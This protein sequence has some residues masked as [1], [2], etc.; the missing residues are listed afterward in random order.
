M[1]TFFNTKSIVG[2]VLI[3]LLL[4]TGLV[5]ASTFAVNM[6]VPA[7]TEASNCCGGAEQGT[8]TDA[9]PSVPEGCCESGNTFS[10]TSTSDDDCEC[11]DSGCSCS[12]YNACGGPSDRC[13]SSCDVGDGGACSSC[14]AKCGGGYQCSGECQ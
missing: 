2:R 14:V 10:T 7:P 3:V 11:G 12:S 4:A 5:F 8:D 9:T 6:F 1:K 13:P